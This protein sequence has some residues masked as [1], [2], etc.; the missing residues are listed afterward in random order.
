MASKSNR[1]RRTHPP[2]M[3]ASAK[4][5]LVETQSHRATTRPF[6]LV[7]CQTCR[8]PLGSAVLERLRATVRRTHHGVLVT[9]GCLLGECTCLARHQGDGA[10]LI[11]QPC[12]TDRVAQGPATWIGAIGNLKELQIVCAWVERGHW[13]SDRL[14]HR[15]CLSLP[16]G[17]RTVATN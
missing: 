7:L 11:L 6:T 4:K 17:R 13:E 3:P 10:V 1:D 16:V 14:P 15:L 9:A 2:D 12:S 5:N 8:S